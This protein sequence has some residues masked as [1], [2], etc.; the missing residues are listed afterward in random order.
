MTLPSQPTPRPQSS[1]RIERIGSGPLIEPTTHRSIG[2][3]IQGP[4]LVAVPDWVEKPLGR[5]YLYFA[6]HKGSYIRMAYSDDVAGPYT[7]YEP[8]TLQLS[9]SHFPTEPIPCTDEQLER[10]SSHYQKALGALGVGTAQSVHSDITT[11]HVASPDVHVDHDEQRFIMYFHGLESLVD[12]QSRVAVSADGLSFE[13]EPTL[14]KG[15]YL[16]A[17]DVEGQRYCLTMP[18][19]FWKLGPGLADAE[20][21]PQLFD[22]NMRHSAVVVRGDILHVLYTIVGDAPERIVHSQIDVSRPWAQWANTE[23]TEVLRPELDWEGAD[24]PC[25]PSLRSVAPG[26]VNQLR[27]PALFHEHGRDYLLYAI[28]GESGIALAEIHGLST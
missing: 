9:E 26:R 15:T 22:A 7:V 3:N 6:D 16:R 8:G 1:L 25:V 10:I 2:A 11:P 23:P 13:A 4:S 17:F 5:Y 18:G 21:G 27:D 19:N 24:Q 12:Q 14:M 20:P 28:A